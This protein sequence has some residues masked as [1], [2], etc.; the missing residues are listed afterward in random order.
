MNVQGMPCFL[1]TRHAETRRKRN[2][3]KAADL[4]LEGGHPLCTSA[5]ETK[6]AVEKNILYMLVTDT[7]SAT[8][9]DFRSTLTR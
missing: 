1:P 7:I 5:S 2:T 8:Y 6:C 3:P 4:R 9:Y